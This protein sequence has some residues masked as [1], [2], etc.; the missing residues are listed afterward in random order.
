MEKFKEPIIK[1][2]EYI[3]K[4][5]PVKIT[6]SNHV[7][8]PHLDMV[9]GMMDK[10]AGPD[11]LSVQMK[12]EM[13]E[14][15]KYTASAQIS[16]EMLM[17]HSASYVGQTLRSKI[18]RTLN[19]DLYKK[20]L[21]LGTKT[22]QSL[23]TKF[24]RF[25]YLKL[26]PFLNKI[27]WVNLPTEKIL[28]FEGTDKLVTTILNSSQYIAIKGRRGPGTF[29]VLNGNLATHLQDHP[30]FIFNEPSNDFPGCPYY[31]GRLVNLDVVVDSNLSWKDGTI[32]IGRREK[33]ISATSLIGIGQPLESDDYQQLAEVSMNPSVMLV[34]KNK[35][36]TI[37]NNPENSYIKIVY[38]LK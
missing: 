15:Q 19:A 6:D 38:N 27:K 14:L 35:I 29:I 12:N 31:I 9:Y 30:S 22:Q 36:A 5:M 2:Q 4:I 1:Q 3:E 33:D 21:E 24:E 26:Y 28:K 11:S 20:I 18:Q 23:Y 32:I 16:R 17:R 7:Q 10:D 8:I 25:L 37:G 13:I 34:S